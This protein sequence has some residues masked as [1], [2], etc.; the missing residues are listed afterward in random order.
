MKLLLR[1]SSL[2]LLSLALSQPLGA[3]EKRKIIID[4]DARG[5]A[6]TDLQAILVLIQSP[7]VELL[8]ITVVSGD[9]WRDEEVAHTLRLLE[10]IG[11]TDIPVLPGAIFPLINTQEEIARWEK[12]YGQVRYQGAWNKERMPGYEGAWN[13]GVYYGPFEIPPLPEGNPTT[14]PAQEDAAHF[15]I[16]MLRQYPGEVTLYAAGP[17]TNLA[18]A[19]SLDPEIP[20][21]AK[22]LVLMGGSLNPTVDARPFSPSPRREF[23]FW[24]DPEAA[25]IVLRAPWPRITLTPVDISIRTRLT[26]SLIEQIGKTDT[27]AAQY[28]AAWAD[29]EYMWDELAAIAWLDPSIITETQTIYMDVNIDHGAGYGDTLTWPQGA[30]PGL[31]EQRVNVIVDVDRERFYQIFRELMTRPTPTPSPAR[32]RSASP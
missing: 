23:N 10:I 31:G 28:L 27:P 9:Q 19:V 14:K 22:E 12:L 30:N 32:Q 1:A 8:G 6:T 11:R 4:Q 26:N 16:R 29:E 7:E 24:W 3:Q 2:V 21:L 17:L 18:L 25:H 20:K 13:R 5:P 15:I